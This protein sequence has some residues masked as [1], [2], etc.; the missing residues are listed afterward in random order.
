MSDN[1]EYDGEVFE[2]IGLGD[3]KGTKRRSFFPRFGFTASTP[4]ANTSSTAANAAAS[5][6]Q[7]AGSVATATAHKR[8]SSAPLAGFFGRRRTVVDTQR[9]FRE[10]KSMSTGPPRTSLSLEAAPEVVEEEEEMITI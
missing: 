10:L 2:D 3:G 8:S 5:T 6:A 4:A 7:E 9:E 1:S